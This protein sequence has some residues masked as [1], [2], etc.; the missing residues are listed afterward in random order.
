MTINGIA[1]IAAR[2]RLGGKHVAFTGAGTSRSRASH[3]VHRPSPDS[4]THGAT[5]AS[6]FLHLGMQFVTIA[7]ITTGN[8]TAW[9]V[10]R[11]LYKARSVGR[12][13][14]LRP[15]GRGAMGEV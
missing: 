9:D 13:E 11:S 2:I 7:M 14:L 12:Y 15:L 6:L 3:T 1:A 8:H 4:D 5:S 10:R